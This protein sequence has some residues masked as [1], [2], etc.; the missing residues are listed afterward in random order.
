MKDFARKCHLVAHLNKKKSCVKTTPPSAK[1]KTSQKVNFQKEWKN[2]YPWVFDDP[3]GSPEWVYCTIC[4]KSILAKKIKLNFHQMSI[5]HK[6]NLVKKPE[7]KPEETQK[8]KSEKKK[9]KKST[10]VES[11]GSNSTKVETIMKL[12]ETVPTEQTSITE[13]SQPLK[14]DGM[15]EKK[16]MEE[17]K[18]SKVRI[19]KPR[20][21][22]V[23]DIQKSKESDM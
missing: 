22:K 18:I 7:V 2:I 14:V 4:C 19:T 6:N 9:K 13:K 21:K 12:E 5:R 20:N 3:S 8:T 10:M 23:S 11:D 15:K 17:T 16:T 1:L